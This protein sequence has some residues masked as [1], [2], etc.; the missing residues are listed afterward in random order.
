MQDD[1]GVDG[2]W[3]PEDGRRGGGE[4]ELIS[5]VRA[6]HVNCELGN[7]ELGIGV[8]LSSP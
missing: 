1:K 3:R 8:E 7:G 5:G 6:G 2:G 4:L